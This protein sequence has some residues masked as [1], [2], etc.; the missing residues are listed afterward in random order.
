ML[1]YMHILFCAKKQIRRI[2]IRLIITTPPGN[3]REEEELDWGEEDLQLYLI[4]GI[5]LKQKCSLL[6]MQG[7]LGPYSQGFSERVLNFLNENT[8]S[9]VPFV[10]QRV[11]NPTSVSLRARDTSRRSLPPIPPPDVATSVSSTLSSGPAT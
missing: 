1:L 9:G 10:A 11:K 8:Y 7:C 5:P 3:E 2:H 6:V 4:Y